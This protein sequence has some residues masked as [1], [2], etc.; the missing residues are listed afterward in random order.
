MNNK[1][2]TLVEMLSTIV[3]LSIVMGIATFGVIGA[4]NKSKE[5]SEEIFVKKIDDVIQSYISFNRLNSS[6]WSIDV[7][8]VVGDYEKCSW[9]A[10]DKCIDAEGNE[11]VGKKVQVYKANPSSVSIAELADKKYIQDGKLINPRNKKNCLNENSDNDPDILL[12]KDDD[13]VYYYYVDLSTANCDINSKNVIVTNIPK[14]LCNKLSDFNWD[15]DINDC[16]KN[17]E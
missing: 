5:K 2:F 16:K 8:N 1:G 9:E 3:V 10:E 7:D 12:Y 11:I 13:A 14:K 4:I 15:N 6:D 17:S